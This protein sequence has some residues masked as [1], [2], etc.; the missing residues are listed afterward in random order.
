MYKLIY[1]YIG[2]VNDVLVVGAL[3]IGVAELAALGTTLALGYRSNRVFEFLK[4][5][6]TK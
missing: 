4:K 5:Y 3:G 1:N 2:L 6:I